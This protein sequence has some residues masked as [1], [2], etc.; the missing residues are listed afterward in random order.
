MADEKK[1]G[2]RPKWTDEQRQAAAAAR[3][4]RKAQAESMKPELILQYGGADTK[5]DDLV[6][7]A[8][9]DFRAVKKRAPI[10]SMKIYVKPEE[11]AA[12]YV[13]NED[14]TGKIPF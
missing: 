13:I 14:Y 11:S 2:G 8:I 12:Y 1:K 6:N 3:A 9:A 5:A 10:T 7:A 4:E